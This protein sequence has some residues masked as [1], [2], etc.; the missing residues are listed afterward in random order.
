MRP[1]AADR[2]LPYVRCV[3]RRDSGSLTLDVPPSETSASEASAWRAVARVLRSPVDAFGC[4]L[5]PACCALC[6]SP[7]PRLSCIPICDACWSEIPV[8][9]GPVCL[10]CADRLLP[11]D[12]PA[13]HCK[14][15]RLAPPRFLRTVAYGPYEDRMRDIIHAMKYQGLGAAARPL[16]IRLAQAIARLAPDAPLDMLVVPVPLHRAKHAQRGFN[17][18]R[19]LAEHAVRALRRTHPGWRLTLA[20]GSVIRQRPT[21]SQA[22]LSPH[23]RRRNVHRAF[24][25]AEP[26]VIA[27]RHILLIDDI[28]TTGAT[29]RSVARELIE[30]RAASVRV[31]T[32]ARARLLQHSSNSIPASVF[33]GLPQ[34]EPAPLHAS[35]HQPSL[36]EGKEDVAG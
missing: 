25:I 5:L 9:D 29:A 24:S 3:F 22:G 8:L 36:C 32:L 6:G 2:P 1:A 28:F 26:Q 11:E 30:A 35:T 21:D 17:Q 33:A 4:A 10:Q 27:G 20:P 14:P 13:A 12:I 18:A 16:G 15:C 34:S 31:A 19:L 23:Q 7:L